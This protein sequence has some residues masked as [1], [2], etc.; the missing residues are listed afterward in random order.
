ML[1]NVAAAILAMER[2]PLIGLRGHSDTVGSRSDNLR[3]ARR[4]ATTV[5]DELV[6]RGVPAHVFVVS[7]AGEDDLIVPTADETAEPLN[8]FVGVW[9]IIS[10]TERAL[11]KEEARTHPSNL[12]C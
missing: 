8:R 9:E 2:P 7:A 10:P 1:D 12:V 5:R 4:R 3:L 6:A 11:R